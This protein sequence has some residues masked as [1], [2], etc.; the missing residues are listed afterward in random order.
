MKRRGFTLIEL[1]VVIAIIAVLIALLLPA[2]QQAREAARR[3]Q[4]KNNLKQWGLG[5]HNYH[6]VTNNF[7]PMSGGTGASAHNEGTMSGVVMMLP[8]LEQGPLW[9]LIANAAGG[10]QGGNPCNNI[11][12]GTL[13]AGSFFG[14]PGAIELFECP[15]STKSPNTPIQRSYCFNV[16]DRAGTAAQHDLWATQ[17][18][19]VPTMLNLGG[20]GN[21]GP[22]TLYRTM[23]VRDIL[24][25]MS[26]TI[27]MAER[28]LGN[29]SNSRDALGRVHVTTPTTP[30]SCFSIV[31]NGFYATASGPLPLMSERW[32][33]GLPYFNSVTIAVPPNGGSC[34]AAA[35][36]SVLPTDT[37]AN[38]NGYYTPSSRHTGGVH[39]L[40]GDGTVRFVN[41]TINSVSSCNPTV[42]GLAAANSSVGTC[43]GQSPYG[44]WG[45]LGTIA[46][47][48]TVN[49]F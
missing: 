40:L 45:A 3:S 22:F 39:V 49:E 48:E 20:D 25:G 38:T 1:L 2:V 13:P 44:I 26:N 33:C 17:P 31:T 19:G 35:T 23:K 15:S 21:R 46:S 32:A 18:V 11:G 5:L 29:P 14:A 37:P 16:G 43:N 42:P 41:E 47:G 6:D 24:D 7:P 12:N 27:F 4:C 9:E 30:N 36:V 34:S 28:D 8:Q 10:A